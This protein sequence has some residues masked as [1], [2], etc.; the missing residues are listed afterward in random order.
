MDASD[1]SCAVQKAV[2]RLVLPSR[3]M[4]MCR[5]GEAISKKGK[6]K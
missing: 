5:D 1:A 3:D 6:V 2:D 4:R